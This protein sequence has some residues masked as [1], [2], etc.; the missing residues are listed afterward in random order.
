MNPIVVVGVL[1]ALVATGATLVLV[2]PLLGGRMVWPALGA[3]LATAI[4]T[5]GL[6]RALNVASLEF[7]IGISV[8]A[9]PVLVLLEAAAIASGADRF[10]RWLLMLAWGLVVFPVS[11]IVPLLVTS[12][13]FAPDCGFEDFGAGLPL[14]AS[15]AAFVVPAWLPAGVHERL[16]LDRPSGRRAIAAVVLL[17]AAMIVWLAH[18]E[19]TI[20]EYTPR[21]ALAALV[22]PLASAAGWLVVDRLR[23]VGRPVARS[24][25]LGLAVGMVVALPGAV[26]VGMPWSAI[27]GLLAGAL[28][29]LVFSVS[30]R[31]VA[32]L[33]AR[34]GMTVLVAISVG[35]LAPAVSGDTVGLIFVARASVL[36]APALVL[37]AVAA[38]SIAVSVP[39][40]L[41]L[42]RH[43]TRD[44]IPAGI[45]VDE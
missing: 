29:G 6:G 17:W 5:V 19:G 18:L 38:F 25:L 9:L 8:F 20:D 2:R 35:F 30:E 15:S 40:W 45:L 21:I 16:Q 13:C 26:S 23:G 27:V 43:A 24:L 28:A 1:A 39:V 22:A 37:A 36:A 42:R 10:G 32:G 4:L 12:G 44:R 7:L 3:A 11:T 31:D 14:I 34:W 33:A 41:V